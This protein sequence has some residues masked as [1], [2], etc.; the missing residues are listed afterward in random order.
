VNNDILLDPGLC[1][2]SREFR[3][4][5]SIEEPDLNLNHESHTGDDAGQQDEEVEDCEDGE[6]HEPAGVLLHDSGDPSEEDDHGEDA[7]TSHD[8]R[9]YQEVHSNHLQHVNPIETHQTSSGSYQDDAD[10]KQTKADDH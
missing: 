5:L 7:S 9:D 3:N 2:I 8:D 1:L 6:G 4:H 10:E